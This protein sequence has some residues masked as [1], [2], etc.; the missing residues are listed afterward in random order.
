[1]SWADVSEVV[2]AIRELCPSPR[3]L[4][5]K[6]HEQALSLAVRDGYHI[7][8]ASIIAAALDANCAVLYSEDMQ[9]GRVIDDRLTIR[10]PFK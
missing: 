9:D 7:Y 8:D 3:P 4:T 10:N 1:M 2:E 5:V 6:L